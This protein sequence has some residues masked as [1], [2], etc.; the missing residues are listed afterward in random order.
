MD[1]P[2]LM[3]IY[4]IIEGR[5]PLIVHTGDYRYDYSLRAA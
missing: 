2:R 3:R 4:E 1:D 5:L